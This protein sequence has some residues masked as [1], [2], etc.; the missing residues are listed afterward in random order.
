MS[1]GTVH[2]FWS[3]DT[4][5]AENLRNKPISLSVQS[6]Q[7]IAYSLCFPSEQMHVA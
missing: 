3:T 5:P 6:L 2:A 7:L 4:Q 1:D